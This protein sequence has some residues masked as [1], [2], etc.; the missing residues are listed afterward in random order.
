MAEKNQKNHQ[1]SGLKAPVKSLTRQGHTAAKQESSD[2]SP[3]RPAP[4]AD[5]TPQKPLRGKAP[6]PPPRSAK[7]TALNSPAKHSSNSSNFQNISTSNDS[8]RTSI[9]LGGG[10]FPHKGFSYVSSTFSAN[11]DEA[12]AIFTNQK[13]QSD[14]N[15]TS[16]NLKNNTSPR[17]LSERSMSHSQVQDAEKTPEV[18]PRTYAGSSMASQTAFSTSLNTDTETSKLIKPKSFEPRLKIASRSSLHRSGFSSSPAMPTQSSAIENEK[19]ELE[20]K[21]TLQSSTNSPLFGLT[22][23]S[24]KGNQPKPFSIPTV[25]DCSKTSSNSSP[26]RT[27]LTTAGVRPVATHNSVFTE[28]TKTISNTTHDIASSGDEVTERSK[29]KPVPTKKGLFGLRKVVSSKHE[30]AKTIPGTTNVQNKIHD[31]EVSHSSS[32]GFHSSPRSPSIS[33]SYPSSQVQKIKN[34]LK[35][36]PI[37]SNKK[38]A[39]PKTNLLHSIF[40]KSD[41]QE[42]PRSSSE[43][44]SH[45]NDS[46]SSFC[47]DNEKDLSHSSSAPGL[48]GVLKNSALVKSTSSSSILT[49]SGASNLSTTLSIKIKKVSFQDNVTVCDGDVISTFRNSLR[50]PE[51]DDQRH[52]SIDIDGQSLSYDVAEGDTHGTEGLG[53][54]CRHGDPSNR[55]VQRSRCWPG[56]S[57]LAYE[58]TNNSWSYNGYNTQYAVANNLYSSTYSTCGGHQSA[59]AAAIQSISGNS[60]SPVQSTNRS[61]AAQAR[62]MHPPDDHHAVSCASSVPFVTRQDRG[63]CYKEEWEPLRRRISA[64]ANPHISAAAQQRSCVTPSPD[65][66]MKETNKNFAD[67]RDGELSYFQT[68]S[69]VI[70][71]HQEQYQSD[72]PPYYEC[73]AASDTASPQVTANQLHTALDLQ[74][75][76]AQPPNKLPKDLL[77]AAERREVSDI[78]SPAMNSL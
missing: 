12:N 61:S 59:V 36:S 45:D 53:F 56:G 55:E 50:H 20:R 58:P 14:T 25:P 48:N 19:S 13:Q 35:S 41:S 60:V 33:E 28:Q 23:R 5:E 64:D 72:T 77:H 67:G 24:Y 8:L 44:L 70:S 75:N 73:C 18:Q 57:R 71:S 66:F 63:A 31:L 26:A 4:H 74:E 78:F 49:D 40:N 6:P 62:P 7:P 47:S 21:N 10:S 34:S 30:N 3:D 51:L 32:L 68:Q 11:Q 29:S 69:S 76:W 65:D 15:G 22:S 17:T 54:N 42:N 39:I 37:N 43:R 27:T 52:T 16:E 38:A 2:P 9:G 46:Q 1:R